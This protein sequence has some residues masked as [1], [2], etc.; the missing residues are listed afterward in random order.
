[1]YNPV[2]VLV[3]P[4]VPL[5]GITRV[6]KGFTARQ[7]DKI[8]EWQTTRKAAMLGKAKQEHRPRGLGM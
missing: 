6:L 4:G 2:H 1:M 5:K 7:A 8:L 3:R